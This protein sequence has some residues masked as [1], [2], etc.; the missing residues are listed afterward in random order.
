MSTPAEDIGQ[1]IMELTLDGDH[2]FVDPRGSVG[3]AVALLRSAVLVLESGDAR[4]ASTRI[5]DAREWLSDARIVDLY[6][7]KYD[8]VKALSRAMTNLQR[9]MHP[10]CRAVRDGF[11]C[12]GLDDHAAKHCDSQGN[13]WEQ[14]ER[15]DSWDGPV[16]ERA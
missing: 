5:V 6:E 2:A 16:R 10:A 9:P 4:L 13:T 3:V 7:R 12:Q 14:H 15:T 11:Q 8:A 1:A